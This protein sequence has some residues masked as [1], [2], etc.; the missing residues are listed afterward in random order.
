MNEL[1]GKVALVTGA[2]SGIGEATASALAEAGVK[3]ALAARRKDRL[4]NLSKKI[5]DQGGQALIVQMDVTRAEDWQT[6]V[7]QTLKKFSRV[8]ILVN[9]AGVMLLSFMRNLKIEEWMRMID[10]NIKGV[11]QGLAAVLPLMRQQNSG[12]II[13]ISS[14]AGLKVFPGSAVYSGT[15]AAVNWISEGL[16]FEL[17]REKTPIRV[18]TIMPGAVAT[19][20]AS[21]ITDQE[22]WEVFK[23]HPPMRFMQAADV[24]AAVIF[25]LTQPPHVDVNQILVRPTEQAT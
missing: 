7:Q 17:A 24:A 10:I 12:E 9:N 13:N 16:R 23:T 25:A 18:T 14:D 1:A 8:D 22:V 21:H 11:L 5:T 2:S 4:G 20:L 6:L 19:E 15:K 3:V